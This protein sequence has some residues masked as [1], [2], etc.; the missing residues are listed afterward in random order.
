MRRD[1]VDPALP[2]HPDAPAVAQA[3]PVLG[4]RSHRRHGKAPFAAMLP[5]LA[6]AA[7]GDF[8]LYWR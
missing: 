3:F 7:T 5:D 1:I 4:T 8:Q 2:Q 6:A